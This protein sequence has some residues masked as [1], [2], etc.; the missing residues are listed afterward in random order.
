MY[1]MYLIRWD[2]QYLRGTVRKQIKVLKKGLQLKLII[3]AIGGKICYL[4][5]KLLKE[6]IYPTEWKEATIISVPKVRGTNRIE[7]YRVINKQPVYE[8]ILEM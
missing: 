7:E 6:G 1:L 2:V 3:E 8:K 5:N 4:V